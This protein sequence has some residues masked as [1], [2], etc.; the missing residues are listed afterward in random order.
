M[1]I[2]AEEMTRAKAVRQAG[3]PDKRGGQEPGLIDSYS[4][5]DKSLNF[6]L[7]LIRVFFLGG[8]QIP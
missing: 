6:I 2:W 1:E 3:R 4:P 8:S 5:G 7:T